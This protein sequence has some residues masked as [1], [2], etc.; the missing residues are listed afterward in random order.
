MR[1]ALL[2]HSA[3]AAHLRDLQRKAD[4]ALTPSERIARALAL[5]ERDLAAY[6]QAHGVDRETARRALDRGKQAG[7]RRSRANE[8]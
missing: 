8:R 7:R 6:M 2:V 3:L 4:A 5:G 1:Y